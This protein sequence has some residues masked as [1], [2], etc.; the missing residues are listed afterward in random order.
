MT[1]ITISRLKSDGLITKE[2]KLVNYEKLELAV[3]AQVIRD[4]IEI[5]NSQEFKINPK[6]YIAGVKAARGPTDEV[7]IPDDVANLFIAEN[8]KYFQ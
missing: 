5:A 1:R 2:N 8:L 6:L 3:T 7:R 4:I